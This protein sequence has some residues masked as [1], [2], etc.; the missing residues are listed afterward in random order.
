MPSTMQ[1]AVRQTAIGAG[2]KG[3][4]G[5]T[6]TTAVG[7]VVVVAVDGCV[8]VRARACVYV[9]GYSSSREDKNEYV[10]IRVKRVDLKEASANRFRRA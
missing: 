5:L 8:C 6:C 1:H 3:S 4:T 7:V 2:G 9:D 10:L